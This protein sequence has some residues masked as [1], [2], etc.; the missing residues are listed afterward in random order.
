MPLFARERDALAGAVRASALTIYL[1]TAAP[2][3]V[4]PTNGRTTTGGGAFQN[5]LAWPTNQMSA[6]SGGAFDNNVDLDFG[7][8]TADVGTVTHWSAYR[9]SDPVMFGT[10]PSTVINNR[11]TFKINSGSLDVT[12]SST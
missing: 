2:T 7:Q 12:I 9:G 8:A 6:V 1:H 4:A 5:G 3:D 10:L 11:D